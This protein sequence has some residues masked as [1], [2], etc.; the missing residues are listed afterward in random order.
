MRYGA[1]LVERGF[2]DQL[3]D[4]ERYRLNRRTLPLVRLL[5]GML[6][7]GDLAIEL[8]VDGSVAVRRKPEL[9]VEEFDRQSLVWADE[10]KR[11]ARRHVRLDTGDDPL[12]T[13]SALIGA[14]RGTL[15]SS[16]QPRSVR[17]TPSPRR[18]NVTLWTYPGSWATA[19][20]AVYAPL[21]R[22]ARAAK[23]VAVRTSKL[24]RNGDKHP[25]GE[26]VK[27]TMLENK[28]CTNAISFNSSAPGRIIV[29]LADDEGPIEVVKIGLIDDVGLRREIEMIRHLS[30]DQRLQSLAPKLSWPAKLARRGDRNAT[31]G[32][33]RAQ[34]R[35]GDTSEVA[36]FCSVLQARTPSPIVHGDFA[37]WNVVITDQEGVVALDWESA[38]F[39]SAPFYDLTFYAVSAGDLLGWWSPTQAAQVITSEARLIRPEMGSHEV[40]V[41]LRGSLQQ[42][43]ESVDGSRS[44]FSRH[45]CA[46]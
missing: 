29:A 39:R 4:P 40:D 3:V 10:S 22:R 37:P 6:P 36:K 9:S 1:V 17:L 21:S 27:A 26:T 18:L 45:C 13:K 12:A 43:I 23:V 15:T 35:P 31:G 34:A 11:Y 33:R 24:R 38:Q 19:A 25:D 42:L 2:R 41:Q 14:M 8:Y 46:L 30:R 32:C 20:V 44:E 16:V 28:V 5:A 7:K